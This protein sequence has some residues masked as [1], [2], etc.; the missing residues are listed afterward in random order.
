M[1]ATYAE[2]YHRKSNDATRWN[3]EHMNNNNKVKGKYERGKISQAGESIIRTNESKKK[4][5]M[6]FRSRINME[7]ESMHRGVHKYSEYH[8]DK[9]SLLVQLRF[10]LM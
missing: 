9:Y 3:R 7:R 5:E 8:F 10:H 1:K 6:V 2:S 4:R